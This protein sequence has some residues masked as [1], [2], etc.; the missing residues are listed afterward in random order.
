MA[1]LTGQEIQAYF[2]A[3]HHAIKSANPQV[4]ASFLQK[5]NLGAKLPA[6]IERLLHTLR[7][8]ETSLSFAEREASKLWL[9]LHSLETLQ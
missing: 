7:A 3:R 6:D 2:K 1:R 5:Y 9:C 4:Y 8:Q